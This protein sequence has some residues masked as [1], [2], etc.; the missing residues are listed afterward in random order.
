VTTVYDTGLR[1]GELVQLDVELLRNNNS[2]LYLPTEMHKDY[3]NKNSPPPVTLELSDD[4]ARLPSAYLTNRWKDTSALFPAR[5]S[6]RISEQGILDMLHKIADEA[7][8]RP[9]KIEGSRGTPDDLT[10]HALRHGVA[11]R[12]MNTE[13]GNT[14]RRP[15]STPS[16]EYPNHR[17]NLR[18]HA[19]GITARP[20]TGPAGAETSCAFLQRPEA[21]I[22]Q[23][24]IDIYRSRC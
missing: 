16:P 12:M 5:S 3:P 21:E 1:V 9:F 24:T 23:C 8:I 14:L 2:E 6:D 4:T 15:Q 22:I 13:D 20:P 19:E 10:P 18:P 17:T 7:E 11:Y